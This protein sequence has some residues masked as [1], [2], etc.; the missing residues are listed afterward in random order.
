MLYDPKWE[1][2]TVTE[3]EASRILRAAAAHLNLYGW[4]QNQLK[5]GLSACLVGAVYAAVGDMMPSDEIQ[6]ELNRR[7]RL[8]IGRENIGA[9]N[10]VP[11]R[12]KEEVID[13]LN[14]AADC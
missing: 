8:S 10:D 3:T 13:A 1:Q 2:K 5:D 9:W 11:G 12:T 14:R 4:C 6:A 7:V